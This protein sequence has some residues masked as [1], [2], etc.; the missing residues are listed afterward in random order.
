MGGMSNKIWDIGIV[1]VITNITSME[2]C[3]SLAEAL[4]AGGIPIMEVT[5]R[6][7]RAEEY[8]RYLRENYPEILVGA[9]TVLTLGQAETA[10]AAGA[11]FLVSPGLNKE[12]VR[13]GNAVGVEML[14]GIATPS[15]LE[16]AMELGVTCVKFFPA[17]QAGGVKAIKAMGGPYK[18]VGFVPTGGIGLTNLADYF[19]CENVVACGGTYMLGKHLERHEWDEISA[20]CKKSVQLMLGLQ[21]SH[22]GVCLA[23]NEDAEAVACQAASLLQL[24]IQKSKADSYFVDTG[25]EIV[26]HTAYG[27]KGFIAYSTPCLERTVRY[28]NAVGSRFRR[29]SEKRDKSGRL[30]SICFEQEIAGLAVQLVQR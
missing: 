13:Y 24:E 26:Q 28:L 5:F 27:G 19:A 8:I 21:L 7:E 10:V 6:M 16:Q 22:V 30:K 2:E 18:N 17:E 15:E 3:A 12:V 23:E 11:Q 4:K 9:G 20:L 1:P 25:L 29:G 14:P